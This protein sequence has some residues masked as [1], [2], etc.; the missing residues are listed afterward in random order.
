MPKKLYK[1]I[2][3]G[4]SFDHFH[5]GHERFISFAADFGEKLHIGVTDKK[6]INHKN[7]HQFIKSFESRRKSVMSY[8]QKKRI[9]CQVS[10]LT[11]PYGPTLEDTKIQ[12]L[13][14]TQETLKGTDKINEV[15]MAMGKKALPVHICPWI[16]DESGKIL[17]ST[18]IRAGKVNRQGQ[19]YSKILEQDLKL[20]ETQ[21][22]YFSKIQGKLI[23]TDLKINKNNKIFIVGDSSLEKFIKN[24]WDYNFA[25]YD[26]R[27]QRKAVN[28]KIIN[29]ISPNL[30]C[31]NPAGNITLQLSKALKSCLKNTYKHLFVDGEE[32]LATVA[33]ALLLPLESI[34]YYG[35]PDSGLVELEITEKVKNNFYEQLSS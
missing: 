34:I 14:A 16:N 23:N 7:N 3:L 17:S 12:A 27:V 19:V 32:D 20:S 21:R 5:K 25:V 22:K 1:I 24:N 33:L 6:I 28:S 15:R 26:K 35:Q 8:C 18:R 30:T 10:K 13:T 4:G 29:S 11:N 2:A 9:N 31:S